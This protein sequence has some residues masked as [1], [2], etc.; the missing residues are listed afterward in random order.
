M[1]KKENWFP[2][3]ILFYCAKKYVFA[4]DNKLIIIF[5]K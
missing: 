5:L 1:K 4:Y 3:N 2:P